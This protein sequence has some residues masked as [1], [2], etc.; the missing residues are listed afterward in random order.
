MSLAIKKMRP[1]QNSYYKI[2]TKDTSESSRILPPSITAQ[3]YDTP[4]SPTES[5]S[6]CPCG[7]RCPR[8][9]FSE[10]VEGFSQLRP[11]L[12]GNLQYDDLEREADNIAD[13][14]L[15][16][17]S[18]KNSIDSGIQNM[19][20]AR[21]HSKSSMFKDNSDTVYEPHELNN[22]VRNVAGN[23]GRPL[24]HLTKEYM[25]SRFRYDFSDVRIHDDNKA[26]EL[27]NSLDALAFTKGND[28]YMSAGESRNKRLLAHELTH[29]V[30]QKHL[31]R[32]LSL[33]QR[34]PKTITRKQKPNKV[35]VG[36]TFN[37]RVPD[38]FIFH[39][40]TDSI[41]TKDAKLKSLR[42]EFIKQA[43][44]VDYFE[45]L[46]IDRT[47][48]WTSHPDLT[49]KRRDIPLFVEMIIPSKEEQRTWEFY[50]SKLSPEEQVRINEEAD[51]QFSK[52]TQ[53]DLGKKLTSEEKS[54]EQ[55]SQLWYTI[56][57]NLIYQKYEID[58]IESFDQPIK[59]FVFTG[60]DSVRNYALGLKIFRTLENL[61][62]EDFAEF[63]STVRPG[64]NMKE[65][66]ELLD[67]YS[68]KVIQRKQHSER[69]EELERTLKGLGAVYQRFLNG[70]SIDED[71]K[72]R[73][74]T[75]KEFEDLIHEYEEAYQY[76]TLQLALRTLDQYEVNL[77][78]QK[79]RYS[80]LEES[81]DLL[82]SLK[83]TRAKKEYELGE[84]KK[85]WARLLAGTKPGGQIPESYLEQYDEPGKAEV[86]KLVNEHPL[87]SDNS[88]P[89]KDMA[90]A[91]NPK[92]IQSLI[93]NY[94]YDKL[95]HI[96]RTRGILEKK[97]DT[98]YKFDLL[99]NKSRKEF[100]Y[101][102]LDTREPRAAVFDEI[103]E[104]KIAEVKTWSA[105]ASVV[106][107]IFLVGLGLILLPIPGGIG[108]AAGIASLT[109]GT[110]SAFKGYEDYKVEKS[111]FEVGFSSDDPS[112]A[113]VVIGFA[114]AA[115]DLGA[116]GALVK[117]VRFLRAIVE[118]SKAGESA[119][120]ALRLARLEKRLAKLEKSGILTDAQAS[121][122]MDNA[123]AQI[124]RDLWRSTF[125][126]GGALPFTVDPTPILEIIYYTSKRGI[127]NFK[128]FRET[129]EAKALLGEINKLSPDAM[130]YLEDLYPK[131]LRRIDT[132][133]ESSGGLKL[134][135]EQELS[136]V[137]SNPP[138]LPQPNLSRPSSSI[139]G[140]KAARVDPFERKAD[141][142][143]TT[144]E[145]TQARADLAE[146]V[147]KRSLPEGSEVSTVRIERTPAGHAQS[148]SVTPKGS[149]V[150]MDVELK[151]K[152]PDGT[153]FKPD[154]LEYLD[155]KYYQFLEHKEVMTIWEKS[156]FS[157]DIARRELEIML[158]E[159]A[160][161]YLKL[162]EYGCVGFKLSTN[163]P[164]LQ[165]L[166]AELIHAMKKHPGGK[167]LFID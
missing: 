52:L 152:L 129:R 84:E 26:D 53:R 156:H 76:E 142:L 4:P 140:K 165:D 146:Q 81:Q 131:A 128:L 72:A 70:K 13:L 91:T 118:F 94:I 40:E 149:S 35:Y 23:P 100:H 85:E 121:K 54:F 135:G 154:G 49:T 147:A 109:Y 38:D 105:L 30:Q 37:V 7:G 62:A 153:T 164:E 56:R 1:S 123:S 96:K 33:I 162:K 88:F 161:I 90:Y 167:G 36:Y 166:L 120:P 160:E 5:P 47:W 73:G 119:D 163:S 59:D 18:T 141:P 43:Y 58:M 29:V 77:L 99:L 20:K 22:G 3:N 92:K 45:A 39:K 55:L 48:Y 127:R 87:L 75:R 12:E 21:F 79:D 144:P 97:P 27:T 63:A 93:S 155:S 125:R 32:N 61:G 95:G 64:T 137:L 16:I 108:I 19:E 9:K 2:D 98:V 113:W 65:L 143:K 74:L 51:R 130:K 157:K 67:H 133:T 112:F 101:S 115:A 50:L 34:K 124:K 89:H 107:A 78:E 117:N 122:V 11:K 86:L 110:Y 148:A 71:L 150:T 138:D 17:D 103:I 28:I 83:E 126:V 136:L 60:R 104:N 15:D 69:R 46:Q 116:L 132:L 80:H 10:N 151:I 31:P 139:A 14:I 134:T 8:C 106:E 44:E 6:I 41:Y 66:K 68:V 159:R 102:M 42:L 82:D 111:A 145:I 158:V 114:G 57:N 25:G 24:D